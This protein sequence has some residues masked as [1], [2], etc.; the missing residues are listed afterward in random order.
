M[1]YR[2]YLLFR[3]LAITLTLISATT[4]SARGQDCRITTTV[5]VL[6]Q[7]E[8]PVL[9]LVADQ[10]KAE[11]GGTPA[12]VLALSPSAKAGVVLLIDASSS[13]ERSWAQSVA[14]AKQLA[15]T[16]GD[17]VAAVL[18]RERIQAHASGRPATDNFLDQLS[19]VTPGRGGT[20]LY[21]TLIEIAEGVKT[22]DVV[23]VVISDGEDNASR[24]SSD[25][26]AALFLRSSWPPVFGL[27]LDY[28]HERPRRGYFQKIVAATGGLIVRPSSASKVPEAG[29]ELAAKIKASFTVT[30]QP[31][32]AVSK[33]ANLKLEVI[34]PD[35]KVRH[36]IHLAHVAEVPGCDPAPSSTARSE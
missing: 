16:A 18:F 35:N 17:R 14:A 8:Q 33:A 21:D 5:R 20:A 1:R 19:T 24:Y 10:L 22:Q 29:N 13:M 34:G 32:Q 23:L 25:Q 26:T 3:V 36:D 4:R 12:K 9:N 6:D 2:L 7:H 28:D 30:L 15:D 27:I 31:L 11:I